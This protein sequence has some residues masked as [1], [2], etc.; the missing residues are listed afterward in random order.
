LIG[1]VA[2][3]F[4]HVVRFRFNRDWIDMFIIDSTISRRREWNSEKLSERLGFG[5]FFG[6]RC[7]SFYSVES[8]TWV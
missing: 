7:G 4:R 6:M 5:T 3:I 2:L 1:L 8:V